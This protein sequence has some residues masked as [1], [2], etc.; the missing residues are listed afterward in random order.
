MLL[1]HQL[2]GRP[3]HQ[4]RQ[5]AG[6]A[7]RRVLH[8]RGALAAWLADKEL[9]SVPQRLKA[10][11]KGDPAA[12]ASAKAALKELTAVPQ[13]QAVPQH[14]LT[15]AVKALGCCGQAGGAASATA[16]ELEIDRLRP[17][18]LPAGAGSGKGGARSGADGPGP[19]AGATVE[20]E[21]KA[22]EASSGGLPAAIQQLARSGRVLACVYGVLQVRQ[23]ELQ[24]PGGMRLPALRVLGTVGL[25]MDQGWPEAGVEPQLPEQQ[26]LVTADGQAYDMDMSYMVLKGGGMRRWRPLWADP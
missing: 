18:Q 13:G 19:A 15:A 8:C 2:T 3:R 12:E 20:L 24:L 6:G 26:L 4:Q 21:L 17:V 5:A 23:S 7:E 11:R 1:G 10:E 9:Q 22:V 16:A 25:G 14:V